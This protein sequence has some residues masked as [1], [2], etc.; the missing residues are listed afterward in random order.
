[1]AVNENDVLVGPTVLASGVTTISLDFD[2][3]DWQQEWLEVYRSDQAAPLTL[4]VDYTVT[5]SGTIDAV[6]TLADPADGVA[7]YSVWLATPIK[8]ESDMARRNAVQSAV[9]NS[10]LDRL[11]QSLQFFQTQLRNTVRFAPT[12]AAQAFLNVSPGDLLRVSDD[13]DRVIGSPAEITVTDADTV[14]QG[15]NALTAAAAA[16]LDDGSVVSIDGYLYRVDSSA[17][18]SAS[19]ANDLGVN[20]LTHHGFR[21]DAEQF[22]CGDF[23]CGAELQA[24]LDYV[25][26][27]LI[28]GFAEGRY[29]TDTPL[30]IGPEYIDGASEVGDAQGFYL[31]I[32]SARGNFNNAAGNTTGIIGNVPAGGNTAQTATPILSLHNCNFCDFGNIIV[33]QQKSSAVAGT[34]AV[35]IT[36]TGNV[37]RGNFGWDLLAVA[38]CERGLV[39]G[40]EDIDGNRHDCNEKCQWRR[41]VISQ[42]RYP[43]RSS[44]ATNDG[45]N[46]HQVTINAYNSNGPAFHADDVAG[47]LCDE[48]SFNLVRSG[49][50][51]VGYI[52][53]A[54]MDMD[55]AS[56]DACSIYLGAG[57]QRIMGGSIENFGVPALVKGNASA[58]RNPSLIVGLSSSWNSRRASDD[59]AADILSP[60]TMIGCTFAGNV[61]YQRDIVAVGVR[62]MVENDG[63]DN[64]V[65]K[66]GFVRQGAQ[67]GKATIVGTTYFF[68]GGDD[69]T[70]DVLSALPDLV[71]DGPTLTGA[72]LIYSDNDFS[73]NNVNNG[74][75]PVAIAAR[76]IDLRQ[77]HVWQI[78]FEDAALDAPQLIATV[79]VTG[80]GDPFNGV[81]VLS[82][83]P[84]GSDYSVSA[85]FDGTTSGSETY[86]LIVSNASADNHLI[87]G[88]KTL[89]LT[90]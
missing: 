69:I 1:M 33:G 80:S 4:G 2:G 66:W 22:G 76:R 36:S 58:S 32:G 65:T 61:V 6:V 78:V 56:S 50:M 13:G 21:V 28:A 54:Q 64:I 62:F 20:G 71:L 38:H 89:D 60:I 40:L 41:T 59:V 63:S 42:C 72:E 37:Q 85:T 75:T 79:S 16:A 83:I 34:T 12:V 9:L 23:E 18:G 87:Y 57:T 17:T 86:D 11:W 55:T 81:T 70:G 73:I 45:W 77:T 30:H 84:G 15:R 10:E 74:E 90:R 43:F 82:D 67:G 51:S 31:S 19:V 25:T 29:L 44:C 8:R 68:D 35:R 48:P 39:V 7:A 46:M 5:G 27:N 52:E 49:N 24:F 14:F 3:T 47:T 53:V 88:W 26:D